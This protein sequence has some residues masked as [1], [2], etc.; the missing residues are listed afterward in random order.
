MSKIIS[1]NAMPKQ[2]IPPY[3]N[4]AN[5]PMTAGIKLQQQQTDNQMAL[6]GSKGGAVQV[7]VP[8][9]TSGVVNPQQ[10]QIS[11]QKITNLAEVS[12]NDASFDTAKT[13]SEVA[14]INAKQ[15]MTY[16][17]NGGRKSR[18]RRRRT[19]QYVKRFLRNAKRRKTYKKM[20][21][22]QKK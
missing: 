15:Q 16:N 13:Q 12:K 22:L 21:G 2:E 18:R 20:K 11:F 3:P 9:V 19:K 10:T 17:G 6:I 7:L 14:S 1:S 5:S 4:G 8:P